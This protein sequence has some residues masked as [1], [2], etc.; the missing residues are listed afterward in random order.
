[1]ASP[2][3]AKITGYRFAGAFYITGVLSSVIVFKAV[4]LIPEVWLEEDTYPPAL[5][6][7][8]F[9]LGAIVFLIRRGCKSYLADFL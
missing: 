1:L 6:K 8:L 9:S 7:F 4:F 3:F 2:P 5:F